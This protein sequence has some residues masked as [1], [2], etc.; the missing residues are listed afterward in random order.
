MRRR[1]KNKK[2]FLIVFVALIVSVGVGG[3]MGFIDFSSLGTLSVLD[4]SVD[5]DGDGIPD[6]QDACPNGVTSVEAKREWNNGGLRR[7]SIIHPTGSYPSGERVDAEQRL[8]IGCEGIDPDNDGTPSIT[9][10]L[11]I[12]TQIHHD[13]CPF[14]YGYFTGGANAVCGGKLGGETTI[15]TGSFKYGTFMIRNDCVLSGCPLPDA[16]GDGVRNEFDECWLTSGQMPNGCPFPDSDDDGVL[17]NLDICDNTP[18]GLSV[19]IQGCPD[20]SELQCTISEQVACLFGACECETLPDFDGDGI[21]DINDSCVE[22]PETFNGYQDA[23]GCPDVVPLHLLDTDGDGIFDDVD[24]CI[25][26]PENFNRFEDK[27]GCPDILPPSYIDTDGDG[28]FDDVDQCINEPETF[29]DHLDFDG[30]PDVVPLN[31]RDTDGDGIFDDVDQC[32]NE[33]ENINNY[34]DNDGCPDTIPLNLIDKDGDGVFDDIDQCPNTDSRVIR[35][36]DETGCRSAGATSVIEDILS[37]VAPE[38]DDDVVVRPVQGDDHDGDGIL[39]VDDEC[40]TRRGTEMF[41]GCPDTA[42]LIMSSTFEITESSTV[43]PTDTTLQST[44]TLQ[45]TNTTTPTFQPP[46]QSTTTTTDRSGLQEPSI[47]SGL[48]DTILY[49]IILAIIGIIFISILIAKGKVK[50]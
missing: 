7:G 4:D 9:W 19:G 14:E 2:L 31:M 15:Q 46:T 47:I 39:N 22:E 24:Q 10:R 8:P 50:L 28:I 30:C 13:Q 41:N 48:D 29:N 49:L 33:R 27:D 18:E 38:I 11:G 35:F 6:N 43:S 1:N 3:Y 40:P 21:Y 36:V 32:I 12:N 16:D 26:E 5:T 37:T 23:D 45:T 44:T 20:G 34:Q 17:D 42:T 25:N